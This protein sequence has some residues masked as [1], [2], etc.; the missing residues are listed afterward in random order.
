MVSVVLS[1]YIAS[2]IIAV[3]FKIVTQAVAGAN[4]VPGMPLY[5]IFQGTA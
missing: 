1:G 4:P 3:V 5:F 2:I